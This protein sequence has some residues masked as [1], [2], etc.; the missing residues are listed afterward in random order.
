MN[1]WPFVI[2]AY[3]VALVA[4]ASLLLWAYASMLRAERAADEIKRK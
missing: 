4:T 1:P 3:A 2:A